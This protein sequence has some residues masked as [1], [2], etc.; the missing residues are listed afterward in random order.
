[1]GTVSRFVTGRISLGEQGVIDVSSSVFTGLRTL[2][3]EDTEPQLNPEG[4]TPALQ[5]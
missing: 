3:A 1:M 5:N 2:T 4:I